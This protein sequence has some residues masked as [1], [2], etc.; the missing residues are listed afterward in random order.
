[1]IADFRNGADDVQLSAGRMKCGVQL[2]VSVSTHRVYVAS[3]S[4]RS[5]S[6]GCPADRSGHSA[7]MDVISRPLIDRAVFAL[8]EGY[9]WLPNR[10]RKS[11]DQVVRTR[12]LGRPALALRG[13]DAVRFFYDEGQVCRHGA[14]PE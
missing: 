13:P 7:D 1:M 5:A 4:W 2:A 8:G 11:P 12:L 3:S 10:M 6:A 14:I 9:A